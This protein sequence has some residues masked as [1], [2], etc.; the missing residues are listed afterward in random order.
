MRHC[1]LDAVRS[2]NKQKKYAIML[3]MDTPTWGQS[4]G[5]MSSKRSRSSGETI[6]GQAG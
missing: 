4:T 6:H 1:S 2:K 5:N 3:L